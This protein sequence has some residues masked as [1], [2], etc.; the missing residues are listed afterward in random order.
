MPRTTD[1]YLSPVSAS[2]PRGRVVWSKHH[3]WGARKNTRGHAQKRHHA[4]VELLVERMLVHVG[5]QEHETM[6][7]QV[8]AE[9]A[10]AT[11]MAGDRLLAFRAPHAIPPQVMRHA[12]A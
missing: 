1:P 2:M 12:L 10:N 4:T 8:A 5:L 11:P 6:M 3:C 9:E 7:V